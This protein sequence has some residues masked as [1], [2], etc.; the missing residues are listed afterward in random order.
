MQNTG[1]EGDEED[2]DSDYEHD[3]LLSSE[4]DG[5]DSDFEQIELS[6][7]D[8]DEGSVDAFEHDALLSDSDNQ[9]VAS[10]DSM[11]T[12]SR[13]PLSSPPSNCSSSSKV[14][15]PDSKPS[16]GIHHPLRLQNLGQPGNERMKRALAALERRII[17]E[18]ALGTTSLVANSK[19]PLGFNALNKR[20]KRKVASTLVAPLGAGHSSSNLL[21]QPDQC[22]HK[23]SDN[24]PELSVVSFTGDNDGNDGSEDAWGDGSGNDDFEVDEL[25]SSPDE[26]SSDTTNYHERD[27]LPHIMAAAPENEQVQKSKELPPRRQASALAA[28][29]NALPNKKPKLQQCPSCQHTT[30]ICS[31]SMRMQLLL[32]RMKEKR[33]SSTM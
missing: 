10:A 22:V 33:S 23:S 1:D 4:N 2:D 5:S 20:A 16:P 31:S 7:N 9:S 15:V 32:R 21:S 29:S 30:C 25:P 14:L 19:T 26:L 18:A 27:M 17:G 6:D 28:G 3:E 11:K 24:I 13:S 8:D 12:P